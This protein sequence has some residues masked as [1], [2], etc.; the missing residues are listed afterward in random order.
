ME[1]IQLKKNSR[2]ELN[3]WVEDSTDQ[4]AFVLKNCTCYQR[5]TQNIFIFIKKINISEYLFPK[6]FSFSKKRK[7][8]E[9]NLLIKTS[10]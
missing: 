8:I 7:L 10:P 4:S 3:D 9:S 6:K 5:K 1:L 2:K